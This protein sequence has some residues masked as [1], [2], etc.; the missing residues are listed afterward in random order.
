M[1]QVVDIINV[2]NKNQGVVT[3]AFTFIT[4]VFTCFLVWFNH[5]I[6]K[7]TKRLR[8]V[9]TEP[10]VE[11]YL[12]P[13]RGSMNIINMIVKN[14]GGGP[15]RD[16]RWKILADFDDLKTHKVPIANM[17]LFKVLHY[18]PA[19]EQLE[20]FFG[21][22]TNI[23]KEPKLK[24]IEIEVE[25]K[26]IYQKNKKN[27]LFKIDLEPFEGMQRIGTPP[28]YEIAKAL[29][30]ISRDFG[31]LKTG[32]AKLRVLTKTEKEE[33]EEQE[34]FIKQQIEQAESEQG[35]VDSQ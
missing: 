21:T 8:E 20:F 16:I 23:L 27:D 19:N 14:S 35:K 31:Q 4:V 2:I 28:D 6:A 32:Y 3:A 13:Y 34:E 7:E 25:Y 22:A 10:H 17:S 9:E 1:E 30:Q 33:F 11:V 18:L 15:A 12:V 29:K 5:R 26:N 24:P